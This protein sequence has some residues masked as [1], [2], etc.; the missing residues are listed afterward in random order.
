METVSATTHG[1]EVTITPHYHEDLSKPSL[2][3]Y[4]HSYE[5]T[6]TNHSGLDVQLLRR[7]WII[8][9]P[10]GKMSGTYTFIRLDDDSTFEAEIPEFKLVADFKNN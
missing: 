6:I 7:H 4:V 1:I 3:K 9:T 10:V 2:H 8:S 5:V